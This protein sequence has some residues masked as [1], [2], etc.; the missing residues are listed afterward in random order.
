M[1]PTQ[2][3]LARLHAAGWTLVQV[4][5]HFN[6]HVMPHGI[7]Q[8]LFGI[9]D[10]LAVSGR[11]TLLVQTTSGSA[12][13]PHMRKMLM[14]AAL[15]VLLHA[16]WE[17]EVHG[18]RRVKVKRGGN[19]IRWDCRVIPITRANFDSLRDQYHV[20]PPQNGAQLDAFGSGE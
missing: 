8:D 12:V 4:V 2:R 6:P 19:A 10:V 16:G 15:P 13:P 18:W 14:S 1:T 11:R 5:E 20:G 17:F 9:G 7:R 3:S